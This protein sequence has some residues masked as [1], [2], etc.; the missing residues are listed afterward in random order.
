VEELIKEQ[1]QSRE[2]KEL[3]AKKEEILAMLKK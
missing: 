3:E 1:S 2:S